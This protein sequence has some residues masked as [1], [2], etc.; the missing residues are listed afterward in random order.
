MVNCMAGRLN[1]NFR[2]NIASG[3]KN[4]IA[5]DGYLF[6]LFNFF[7]LLLFVIFRFGKKIPKGFLALVVDRGPLADRWHIVL[8][9]RNHIP[10]VHYRP[11]QFAALFLKNLLHIL[12]TLH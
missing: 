1:T 5:K 12:I 6:A 11:K 10:N 9:W 4:R 8:F 2:E 3:K 7:C